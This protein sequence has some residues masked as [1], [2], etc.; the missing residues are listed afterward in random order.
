MFLVE[1]CSACRI[2]GLYGLFWPMID[3]MHDFSPVELRKAALAGTVGK[4]Q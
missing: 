3:R 1:A 2:A 4:Q